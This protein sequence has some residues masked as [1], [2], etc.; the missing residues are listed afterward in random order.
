MKHIITPTAT[1]NAEKKQYLNAN[2][3][4]ERLVADNWI[5]NADAEAGHVNIEWGGLRLDEAYNRCRW[6]I[7]KGN[8]LRVIKKTFCSNPTYRNAIA[9]C[10]LQI[11]E[12][13]K[14]LS[15][16]FV[17]SHT[18]IPWKAIRGM[19]NVVAH[20]YGHID[21]DTIWETSET[22]IIELRDFCAAQIRLQ[23]GQ[24]SFSDLTI[25]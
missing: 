24:N 6:Q 5:N 2:G 10:L 1:S 9:L 18:T 20:E 14:K 16:E 12:L 13:V 21:I 4:S 19:R 15:D 3:W 17:Q 11:G 8:F 22:G 25:S 7:F 23:Q